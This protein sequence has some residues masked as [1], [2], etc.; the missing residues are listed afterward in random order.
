MNS[1][2]RIG[3]TQKTNRRKKYKEESRRD[4]QRGDVQSAVR[5]RCWKGAKW[6]SAH[7]DE[8]V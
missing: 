6:G 3:R 8:G 7:K 4:V 2:E 5:M 1:E